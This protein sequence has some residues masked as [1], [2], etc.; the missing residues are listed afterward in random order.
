MSGC[1]FISQEVK[2]APNV[3]VPSS[4]AGR[5][6]SVAVRV[7][8]E[9]PKKALGHRGTAYGAAA[10]IT[11]KDDLAEVVRTEIEKGLK[12]KGFGLAQF[13]Q[14]YPVRL[15]IEVRLLEYT[16]STG[17]WTGG[18][19]TRGALKAVAAKNGKGYEKLYRIDDEERVIIVPTSDH[20]EQ[21][22]ND[23]LGKLIGELFMDLELF[24]FLA[25]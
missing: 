3:S 12:A 4:D 24:A 9:R 17:F 7:V 14:D 20:N 22:I 19:H 2:F 1:A 8:D 11:T 18:I 15:A 10:E 5:G 23:A 6:V 16:T 25:K 21:R 13:S